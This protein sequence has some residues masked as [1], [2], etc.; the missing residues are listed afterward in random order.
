MFHNVAIL[1]RI[2]IDQC[3]GVPSLQ[4]MTSIGYTLQEITVPLAIG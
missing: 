3:N 4:N 1:F 2:I